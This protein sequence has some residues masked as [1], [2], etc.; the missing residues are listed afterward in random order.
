MTLTG[1]RILSRRM[2][3]STP[4]LI[5]HI[6]FGINTLASQLA[7]SGDLIT[8]L[9]ASDKV[10][11]RYGGLNFKSPCLKAPIPHFPPYLPRADGFLPVGDL[12]KSN[13]AAC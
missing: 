9:M 12:T 6:T 7:N 8:P 11:L 13:Q 3:H 10:R 4:F 2:G 5:S 1:R